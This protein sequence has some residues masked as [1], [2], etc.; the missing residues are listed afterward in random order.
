MALLATKTYFPA[1]TSI[2]AIAA[3]L[4]FIHH[5]NPFYPGAHWAPKGIARTDTVVYLQHFVEQFHIGV[6]IFFVLSGL[7]ITWRY[8]NRIE[9][10]WRWARA[11][12]Q[13][14][15]ARIYPLYFLLTMVAIVCW[16]GNL[17]PGFG[18]AFGEPGYWSLKVKLVMTFLNLSLL[19]AF[20]TKYMFTGLAAGWSLTVE[21]CF[22]ATAPLVLL[23]VRHHL[24]RIV[25]FPLFFLLLG[26]LVV[27]LVKLGTFPLLSRHGF[28]SSGKFMLG[29]TFFGRATEFAIGMAL[30]FY[31]KR[32]QE[33]T[34]T[35]YWATGVGVVWILAALF[36]VTQAE[37]PLF[38]TNEG[39]VTYAGIA[40]NNLF[41]PIGVAIL[42]WGLI[43]ER[44]KFRQLLETNVF[45]I[46]GKSSYA[47]Y[48][49]HGGLL[50]IL[51]GKYTNNILILFTVTQTV[52]Y[53]LWR[54]IEEPLHIRL[55]ANKL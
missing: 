2:R 12:F 26:V 54:F 44:S 36:M 14:R 38:R 7:L 35:G 18:I 31:M 19:R 27:V 52:A 9:P 50:S 13:N 30:A 22:Y 15:F 32:Q 21:E 47:F 39:L 11:Y 34:I 10:T 20:F 1:L 45:Q 23:A 5:C 48:L 33:R 42:F 40:T 43:N 46:L 53:L 4:I 49:V 51:V 17:V 3:F 6:S 29:W 37:L 24:K 55:R 28:V 25:F 41:L 16:W 8:E